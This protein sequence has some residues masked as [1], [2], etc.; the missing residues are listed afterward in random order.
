MFWAYRFNNT[1]AFEPAFLLSGFSFSASAFQLVNRYM[2]STKFLD[3]VFEKKQKRKTT[4]E[5]AKMV[6]GMKGIKCR[7]E[8]LAA[9]PFF[10]N[11]ALNELKKM[12]LKKM[13]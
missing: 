2:R 5:I 13:W 9:S 8:S 12:V 4:E 6:Q 11:F 3:K 1:P 7:K 10:A